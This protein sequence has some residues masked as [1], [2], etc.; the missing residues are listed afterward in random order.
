MTGGEAL[1]DEAP[2][3]DLV[4]EGADEKA[5][6]LNGVGFRIRWNGRV[7]YS[8]EPDRTLWRDSTRVVSI[9]DGVIE[10]EATSYPY[11]E[12]PHGVG[13]IRLPR[14]TWVPRADASSEEIIAEAVD[15]AVTGRVL[16]LGEGDVELREVGVVAYVKVDGGDRHILRCESEARTQNYWRSLSIDY[17]SEIVR[18][19]HDDD[20]RVYS[21]EECGLPGDARL[22]FVIYALPIRWRQL[23]PGQVY[24]FEMLVDQR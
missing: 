4:V 8:D 16:G 6:D 20:G 14:S 17:D 22:D 11:F 1:A 12:G 7:G 19:G 10:L 15:A 3:A 24:G 5:D 18:A 13:G 9:A 21:F 2:N 23:D